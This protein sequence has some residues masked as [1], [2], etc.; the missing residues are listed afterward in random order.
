V[1]LN[2]EG[3]V[4]EQ[5]VE[6]QLMNKVGAAVQIPQRRM[7]CCRQRIAHDPWQRQQRRELPGFALLH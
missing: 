3:P 7:R 5:K 2:S 1:E 6:S 4:A